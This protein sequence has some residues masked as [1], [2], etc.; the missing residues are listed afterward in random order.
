MTRY[1]P[2][3]IIAL[4]VAHGPRLGNDKYFNALAIA[5]AESGG[6]LNAHSPSND[7]GL[8]QINR[9]H[10]GDGIINS[11]NWRN[12]NVQWAEM[13]KLSSGMQNWAAWCTA[14]T[15]PANN[16][17]HG[18]LPS[19]QAGSAADGHSEVASQ[20]IEAYFHTPPSGPAP[21]GLTPAEQDE[22][23]VSA[24]FADMRHYYRSVANSQLGEL[25]YWT[26]QIARLQ[27]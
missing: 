15:R 17:G 18:F 9:I 5:L 23:A 20:A 2:R 21:P 16:C 19:F 6:D 7:Y 10:F 12:P 24:A 3:Q 1:S 13:W 14:W 27:Q 8:W 25:Q 22:R 26:S 11:S 4:M